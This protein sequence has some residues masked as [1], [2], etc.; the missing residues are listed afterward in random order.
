MRKVFVFVVLP[1]VV[2]LVSVSVN[3]RKNRLTLPTPPRNGVA[4][5]YD[6]ES[7]ELDVL[8]SIYGV[9]AIEISGYDKPTSS[10]V[11]TMFVKNNTDRNI[12]GL[13][14]EL[15]YMDLQ[16]NQLHERTEVT[17]DQIGCD[18]RVA[19]TLRSWDKQKSY[20]YFRSR[21]A[22]R[23]STPYRVRVCAK[24]VF[25]ERVINDSKSAH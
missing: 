22:K 11:E 7:V 23:A 19:I 16:G 25:F 8:D 21:K 15:V 1:I 2:L 24:R 20:H 17:D 12:V 5:K 3:A 4:V 18:K 13:E 9:D 6:Q 10:D 14:L